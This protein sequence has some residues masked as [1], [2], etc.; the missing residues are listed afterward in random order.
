MGKGY[1][2]LGHLEIPLRLYLMVPF[3]L[4]VAW[5]TVPY[6]IGMDERLQLKR[7]ILP[8]AIS[9]KSHLKN[10]PQLFMCVQSFFTG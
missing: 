6:P 9:F 5:L 8:R 3:A 2:F 4:D 7:N 10:T 1:H